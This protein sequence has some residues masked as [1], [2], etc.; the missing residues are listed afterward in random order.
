MYELPC[1]VVQSLASVALT[2]EVRAARILIRTLLTR[3][4]SRRKW[5]RIIADAQLVEVG[6]TAITYTD[7]THVLLRGAHVIDMYGHDHIVPPLP[8]GTTTVIWVA[9][10]NQNTNEYDCKEHTATASLEL[11]EWA[12]AYKRAYAKSSDIVALAKHALEL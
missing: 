9:Y 10:K 8:E 2:P 11:A 3:V 12:W 1:G 4:H 7:H 6:R 5:L